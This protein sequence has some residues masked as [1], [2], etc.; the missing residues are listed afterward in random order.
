[1]VLGGQGHDQATLHPERT[2]VPTAGGRVGPTASLEGFL[3]WENPLPPLG[4]KPNRPV[5]HYTDY[6]VLAP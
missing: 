5:S 1:M 4:I 6:V 2:P 3:W